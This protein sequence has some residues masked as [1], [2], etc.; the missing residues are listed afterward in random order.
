[1]RWLIRIVLLIFCFYILPVAAVVVVRNTTNDSSWWQLRRDSSN[2][3][4]VAAH[5][6]DAVIQVYA[7]R[8]ASWRGAF[9][10]HTWF[11]TKKQHE[12]SYTRIEVIGYAV[13]WG[14]DAVRIRRG[15]PD[16]YWFGNHPI[17]LSDFRGQADVD[18]MI[19]QLREAARTYKYNDTYRVWPGPNSNT[20]TAYMGR[21]FPQLELELPSNALGKDY[22]PMPT[23]LA[24]TPSGTGFQ[25]SLGGYAGLMLSTQEGF[26]LNLLGLTAGIDLNRPALKLPAVGRI[27]FSNL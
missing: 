23:M 13:R 22:L 12:T 27:G 6:S 24:R 16:A 18:D 8:A 9:G 2:Q 26:E 25:L 17:L 21:K 11:A 15:V 14:N 19:D 7:A 20:F 5:S 10:V 1:M 4:P 3:A